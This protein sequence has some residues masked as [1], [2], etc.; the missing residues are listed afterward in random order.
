MPQNI[1]SPMD[2]G[3]ADFEIGGL[4]AEGIAEGN[5]PGYYNLK[6][7][8]SAN[9]SKQEIKVGREGMETLFKTVS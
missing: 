2:D 3:R 4:H 6:L 8:A 7:G 5:G 9:T 1:G